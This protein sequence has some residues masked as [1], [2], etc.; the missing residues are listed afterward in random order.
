MSPANPLHAARIVALS[1]LLAAGAAGAAPACTDVPPQGAPDRHLLPTA[2]G[3][4]RYTVSREAGFTDDTLWGP[5]GRVKISARR[6]WGG[7]IVFF[8]LAAGAPA[9]N[10]IDAGDTGREV[11]MALY[12]PDRVRQGCA[13]D[14]SCRTGSA[15]RCPDSISFLGWNPVQGGNKCNVGSRVTAVQAAD[16]ALEVEVAPLHW[17]PDW[18]EATCASSACAR[19][20][21][22]ALE[23][24]VRFRERLRFVGDLV[25]ELELEAVNLADEARAATAQEFPT[26]YVANGAGGAPNLH[27]LLDSEGRRVPIDRPAND[28]FF[29]RRFD[30]PRGWVAYQ[31]AALDYGVGLLAENRLRQWQGWQKPGVFNNVRAVFRFGLAPRG[32]VR[33]RS[34]LMLGSAATIAKLAERL[35]RSLPPFG[36]LERPAPD[37]VVSGPEIPVAGWALDNVGVSRVEL[38]L[39]GKRFAVLAPDRARS[40]V[41]REWPG[42]A[43]C[44]RPGFAGT[45]PAAGL[46]PC[47][48]LV[49]A[50]AV[51][52]DGNRRAIGSARF[53][54]ETRRAP[55]Q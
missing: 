40:D 18:R 30:S 45:I 27:V 49:E 23:A 31:N 50:V 17:N 42:Y 5:G 48:H 41:C 21:A 22:R 34:Y 2:P 26:L 43:G 1:I 14:A 20:D 47:A 3:S 38:L 25:V 13:H 11:Q 29:A 54:L 44:E 19:A 4:G 24:D 36:A 32:V 8:G 10:V 46:T 16:G 33:A 35:E 12:D 7:A 55:G 15:A 53:R 9:T 39:D 6:E 51:D 52:T 28:G 37:E